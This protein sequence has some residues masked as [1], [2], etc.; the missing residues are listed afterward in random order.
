MAKMICAIEQINNKGEEAIYR[1]LDRYL[2]DSY[3]VYWNREVYGREFDFC[4]LI[5][6]IGIAVI[7]VKGWKEASVVDVPNGEYIAVRTEHGEE[8][9]NPR[10]QARAY[11]FAV[12]NHIKTKLGKQ[13]LV[14]HLISYPFI[15]TDF[16]KSKHMDLISESQ[17]TF[18]NDDLASQEV[19]LDK[20]NKAIAFSRDWGTHAFSP[21]LMKQVRTLFEPCIDSSEEEAD[22]PLI[23]QAKCPHLLSCYSIVSYIP[24]S[25]KNWKALIDELADAYSKGCRIYSI[26]GTR[27]MLVYAGETVAGV[28]RAKGLNVNWKG[29]LELGVVS[30]PVAILGSHLSIFN[31][32]MVLVNDVDTLN[33]ITYFKVIDGD[34]DTIPDAKIWLSKLDAC[35]AFNLSQ[36][37][38]EHSKTRMNV[39]VRA[40]AGTGK[41]YAMI[42]RVAFLCYAED[43]SP[44]NLVDRI[45]MITFTNDAA[46]NM[47]RRLKKT[48]QNY[49]MLTGIG[50]FLEMIAQ[51]DRMQISTIHS[52]AR[53]IIE[54]LGTAAGYGQNLKITSGSYERR[55]LLEESLEN[56]VRAQTEINP[57]YLNELGLPVYELREK[58]LEFIG[59]LENKSIDVSLVKPEQFGTVQGNESLHKLLGAV[60]R[61]TEQLFSKQLIEENRVFLGRLM[62]VL[63]GLVSK[64]PERLHEELLFSSRYMFIDEFQDTDD[65]QIGVLKEICRHVGYSMFVVGD[66]KQCIYRFRGAEERAFD[67]LKIEEAL[68]QWDQF[69]LSKN[70]R[71]DKD[72]LVLYQ[73]IFIVWGNS[74]KQLLTYDPNT[75]ALNSNVSLNGETPAKTYYHPMPII[76]ESR[77]LPETF[78]EVNRYTKVITELLSNGQYLSQEERTIA[79]LVR[80]NWQADKIV[81]YG[82]DMG[83]SPI[84]TSIGGDL[85][86]SVPALELCA[87]L[88]ALLH[89]GPEQLS[90]LLESNFFGVFLDRLTMYELKPALEL[91][92]KSGD[93]QIKYLISLIDN[94]LGQTASQG[95][96]Q[97]WADI[98][99]ALRI[100]PVLQI[101]RRLYNQLRPWVRFGEKFTPMRSYYRMNVDLLFEKIL[102]GCRVDNLTLHRLTTFMEINIASGRSE[103]CR[104]PQ[105]G[106][107]EIR[108]ICTTVHKS[109]GLEYGY[110]ILPYASFAIDKPKR[111]G[112]DILVGTN[113]AIGY[114]FR[115]GDNQVLRNNYYDY[116]QEAAERMNEETRI[117]YVAMTRAIRAFSWI[118][119]K[120]SNSTSWQELLRGGAKL[121]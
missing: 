25:E 63:A 13:P 114:S 101:I 34:I 53:R 16:Y 20:L 21:L 56:Y 62:A 100:A 3:V 104:W 68:E 107:N 76:A 97:S 36:Y 58:L 91:G 59:R 17:L 83:F 78:S 31:W 29:D 99:Q 96:Y 35:G 110:V 119:L 24:A 6:E 8:H 5:P 1:A 22:A 79:I 30:N 61:E 118:D 70:Y 92:D 57:Q 89:S 109:K 98:L 94:M 95:G 54:K 111:T 86:K 106:G 105:Q 112:M 47:K 37:Q 27:E 103:E 12:L 46:E 33:D 10:V 116:A 50:D 52:Y 64:C 65:V 51:V 82:R 75:D 80:E 39:L 26:V 121:E 73:N 108:I 2:D 102:Q 44:A 90:H 117:L 49:Y 41:T 67:H 85:Y 48:F 81:K 9:I 19:F 120:S 42:L 77:R 55:M 18:A 115:Y 28:L 66:V 32:Q 84:Q 87:L 69:S 71:T 60:L 23:N 40:G 38:V 7:E 72:L 93:R 45:L 43:I 74:V 113:G 88:Q 4:V 11:R 15:S 14:F